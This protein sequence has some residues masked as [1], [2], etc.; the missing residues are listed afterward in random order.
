MAPNLVETIIL[1]YKYSYSPWQV[2]LHWIVGTLVFWLLIENDAISN[3][4]E[5]MKSG[6][7]E[8]IAITGVILGHVYVGLLVLM[9]MVWRLVLKLK[10]LKSNMNG[11]NKVSLILSISLHYF[12]YVILFLMPITGILAWYFGFL[13]AAEIHSSM[14]PIFFAAIVLH[15]LGALVHQAIFGTGV[16]GRMISSRVNNPNKY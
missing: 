14:V 5:K 11:E 3:Y 15:I 1:N 12:M 9:L 6:S 16:I 13:K 10:Y 7:N 2:R 8:S 4:W